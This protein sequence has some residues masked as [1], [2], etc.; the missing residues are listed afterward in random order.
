MPVT[1]Q[2]AP[3][4]AN[5][6]AGQ[7]ASSEEDLYQKA[8]PKQHALT[9][10]I[11]KTSLGLQDIQDR[12]ISPSNNGFVEAARAAYNQHHHLT[13]RPEDVWFAIVN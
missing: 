8:C 4:P 9:G 13:I 10:K 7:A 12:N 3:H 1:V 5:P 6:C 2:L 11:L